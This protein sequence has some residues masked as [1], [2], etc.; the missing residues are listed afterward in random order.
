M[1]AG[2]KTG[3]APYFVSLQQTF[4]LARG[5]AKAAREGIR[6]FDGEMRRLGRA[7]TLSEV[8]SGYSTDF[9][10]LG[11][12]DDAA[13]YAKQSVELLGVGADDAPWPAAVVLYSAGRIAEARPVEALLDRVFASDQMYVRKWQPMTRA[14]RA[15]A[16]GNAS[17]AVAAIPED[18]GAERATPL[19]A[20]VR[21]EALL[22]A[23]RAGEAAD[24][25]RRVYDSR[26]RTAPSPLGPVSKIWLAR[27][28]AKAGDTAGARA[29]YQD[30][31]GLWKDADAD[32]PLLVEAR[33]EYAALN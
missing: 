28:L 10:L 12:R 7:G 11:L 5:Q 13:A 16:E 21:G 33:K 19:M 20:L 9:A 23:G 6:T 2:M 29:A 31:F 3:P 30:A 1:H 22:A 14:R 24:A 27:A 18:K 26:F 17:A 4:H 32:L 15:L 25:F 8:L